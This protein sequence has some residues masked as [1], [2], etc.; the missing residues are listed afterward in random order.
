MSDE[1]EVQRVRNGDDEREERRAMRFA[2][3]VVTF[4]TEQKL[5]R[6][7]TLPLAPNVERSL[8]EWHATPRRK[9]KR[10]LGRLEDR[11]VREV[12]LANLLEL[13]AI[14]RGGMQSYKT[15]AVV[16]AESWA[17]RLVDD[18]DSALQSFCEEVP[19]ADRQQLRRLVRAARKEEARSSA[20]SGLVKQL[21]EALAV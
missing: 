3:K 1:T 17:E 11:M 4:I 21:A 5:E 19:N 9:G 13:V 15:E 6:A 16:L 8:R 7:L 18:G 20:W 10:A 12:R 14:M 2:R